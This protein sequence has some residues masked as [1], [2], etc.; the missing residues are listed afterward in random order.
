MGVIPS[1]RIQS[2]LAIAA[3]CAVSSANA[4]HSS[5]ND[6]MHAHYQTVQAMQRALIAGSLDAARTQAGELNGAGAAGAAEGWSD[7]FAAVEAAASAAQAAD[8]IESAARAMADIGVAC[9]DCHIANGVEVVF[10]DVDR[11]SSKEKLPHHMARHQWAADRMWEGLIGPSAGAWSRGANLL[12]ES[13]IKTHS[14]GDPNEQE[15]IKQMSRRVHQLA[16]NA[17]TVSDASSKAE[18]YAEFLANCAACH[19]AVG[20]GPKD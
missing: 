10:D 1:H 18:I 15:A 20:D 5:V 17:T 3:I 16:A 9:G 19:T 12:F 2:A 7:Y 14:L 13:P 11:P 6:E 4:Q 8:S